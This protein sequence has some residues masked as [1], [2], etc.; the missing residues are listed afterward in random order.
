MGP[1]VIDGELNGWINVFRNI[2][3]VND[4]KIYQVLHGFLFKKKKMG[5][6]R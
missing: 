2:Y 1:C 5:A 6:Y 3:K 4:K